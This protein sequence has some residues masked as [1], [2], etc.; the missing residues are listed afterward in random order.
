MDLGGVS[1]ENRRI[2]AYLINENLLYKNCPTLLANALEFR[3]M[4]IKNPAQ[5]E[6]LKNIQKDESVKE[7]LPKLTQKRA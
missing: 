6:V 1:V 4:K 7:L 5:Q 2:F 3:D